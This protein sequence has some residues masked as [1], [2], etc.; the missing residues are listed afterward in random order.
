MAEPPYTPSLE[1]AGDV[2]WTGRDVRRVRVGDRVLADALV[3]GPR[4]SGSHRRWGGFARYA[5][6]PEPAAMPI[7]EGLTHDQAANLLGNYETAYHVLV[8]RGRLAE[9]EAVLVLGATGS[10]GLAAVHVAGILGATVIAVGRDP[11]KLAQVKAHGADHVVA[12]GE[13]GAGRIRDEV[14]AL[15]GGKGV[16]VVWDGVGGPIS[17]EAIRSMRFGGRLCIVGWAAPPFVARGKGRRG[18]PNANVLPTNLIQMKGLDILGCPAVIATKHDP[19][20]RPTRLEWIRARIAEGRLRP[21]V[22][23]AYALEDYAEAMTAKWRSRHLGG[24]VLHP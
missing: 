8:H 19:T 9:G 3:T 2:V 13:D 16:H 17:V 7:P 10:T 15:T 4:S 22:G 14:K 18:A 11:E 5:V 6:V 21:H 24:C 12:V 23:P 20:L 1:Y